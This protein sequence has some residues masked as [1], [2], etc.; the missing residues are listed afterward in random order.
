MDF[1]KL[2]TEIHKLNVV[3]EEDHKK[4]VAAAVAHPAGE[5]VA[6]PIDCFA[7]LPYEQVRVVD[8]RASL[9]FAPP[10]HLIL[11]RDGIVVDNNPF[12]HWD[13]RLDLG[14]KPRLEL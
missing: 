10:V 5:I 13:S 3:A 14:Y 2:I 12:R 6:R 9:G 7:Q 1:D 11:F 4:Q 8:N